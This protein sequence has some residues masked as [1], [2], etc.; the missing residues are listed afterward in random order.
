ME[1]SRKLIQCNVI[2]SWAFTRLQDLLKCHFSIV[3]LKFTAGRGKVHPDGLL[4]HLCYFI[5]DLS[6]TF[7]LRIKFFPGTHREN[8]VINLQADGTF[9]INFITTKLNDWLILSLKVESIGS[10]TQNVSPIDW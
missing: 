3:H 8:P 7:H 2:L 4:L 6:L 10:V 5:P 1:S 9:L